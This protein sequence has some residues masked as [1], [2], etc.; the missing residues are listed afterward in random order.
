MKAHDDTRRSRWIAAAVAVAAH[1]V[2][3][4]VCML[5]VLRYPRPGVEPLEPAAEEREITFEE[6]VELIVGGNYV[7]AEIAAPDPQ[8]ALSAGANVESAPPP[9]PQPT[10]EE[11]QEKKRQEI[12]RRVTFNTSTAKPEEGD[13]G[14]DAAT[15]AAPATSDSPQLLG[16]EGFSLGHYAR[17]HGRGTGVIAV[18]VTV[19]PDGRVSQADFYRAKSTY[20]VLADP[21]ALQ[22]C[23]DAARASLCTVPKG[24]T[25]PTRGYIIYRF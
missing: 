10:Q 3:L 17:P 19:E 23:I 13:G 9:P 7:Q 16:L 2:L 20:D 6:T 11:I 18:A 4:L 25:T 24:V 15:V 12:S 14:E 21:H 5:A 22:E 8:P 1:L